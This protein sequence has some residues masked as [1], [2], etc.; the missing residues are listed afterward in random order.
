MSANRDEASASALT[1]SVSILFIL[2]AVAAGL[3]AFGIVPLERTQHEIGKG[4]Y[5]ATTGSGALLIVIAAAFVIVGAIINA[6]GVSAPQ[7]SRDSRKRGSPSRPEHRDALDRTPEG[8]R[9]TDALW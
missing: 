6:R 1:L 4:E 2:A 7:N 8:E 3:V 9:A 5:V